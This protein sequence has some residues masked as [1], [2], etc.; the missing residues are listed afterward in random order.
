MWP[1]EQLMHEEL[2]WPT[3][4]QRFLLEDGVGRPSYSDLLASDKVRSPGQIQNRPKITNKRE[5]LPVFR[6]EAEA[7]A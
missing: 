7:L 3:C 4:Y 6:P 5:N 2:G 1:K